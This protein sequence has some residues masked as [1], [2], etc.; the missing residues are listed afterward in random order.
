M[1]LVTKE[2]GC[3]VCIKKFEVF[4]NHTETLDKCPTCGSNVEQIISA[5]IIAKVG[6]PRTIGSQI[7]LNNKRNPLT[8][9]K[10]FGVDA[11]KKQ[12]Q[13]E[14]LNKI[15]KLDSSGMKNF[16]EKGTL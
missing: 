12:K 2:Y 13:R 10:I 15:S 5:P 8:R 6:G 16:L 11:E 3:D 9:E 14:R 7:E 1:A 4:Q